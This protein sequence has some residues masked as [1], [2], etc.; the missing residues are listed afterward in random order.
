MNPV[1]TLVYLWGRKP[2]N[3]GLFRTTIHTLAAQ[4]TIQVFHVVKFH[5][6][7]NIQTH[8]AGSVAA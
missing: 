2:I 8:R 6:L 4:N 5:H 3:N 1:A 7:M